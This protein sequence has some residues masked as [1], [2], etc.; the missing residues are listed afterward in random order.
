M[1]PLNQERFIFEIN[2]T[3]FSFGFLPNQKQWEVEFDLH[4]QHPH[5][6]NLPSQNLYVD[7]KHM[8]VLK[9]NIQEK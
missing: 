5:Y 7:Y 4:K 8:F 1:N 2:F 6:S 9:A 3:K